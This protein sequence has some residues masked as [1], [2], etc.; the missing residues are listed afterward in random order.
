MAAS[1]KIK[2]V[3]LIIIWFN[4]D[5]KIT[6][7]KNSA[8]FFSYLETSFCTL[9]LGKDSTRF[10]SVVFCRLFSTIID[11]YLK[12]GHLL[13]GIRKH[14]DD[15]PSVSNHYC[16][17]VLNITQSCIDPPWYSNVVLHHQHLKINMNSVFLF[18]FFSLDLLDLK[19][20]KR[21][22]R[23]SWNTCEIYKILVIMLHMCHS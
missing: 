22:E 12:F 15:L 9:S 7:H 18:V 19:R 10:S 13:E 1:S 6:L 2:W 21:L 16:K 5:K 20:G 4:L 17:V 11:K 8:T 14:S 23:H 3:E